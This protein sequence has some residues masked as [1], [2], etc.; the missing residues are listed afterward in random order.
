M[1]ADGLIRRR[2]SG[3][4][5]CTSGRKNRPEVPCDT[6]VGRADSGRLVVRCRNCG[7]DHVFGVVDGRITLMESRTPVRIAPA[8]TG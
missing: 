1:G 5:E 2:D 8:R 7:T 4:L 3:L 6:L